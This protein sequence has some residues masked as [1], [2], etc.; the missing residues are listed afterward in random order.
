MHA[1][2]Y[3]LE[4]ND[5]FCNERSQIATGILWNTTKDI[6]DLNYSN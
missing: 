6:F 3:P 2:V 4:L 5:A 1:F